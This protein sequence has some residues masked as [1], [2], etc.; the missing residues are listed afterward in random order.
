MDALTQRPRLLVKLQNRPDTQPKNLQ[1]DG[2]S[3]GFT[4]EPLFDPEARPA[5]L[6]AAAQPEWYAMTATDRGDEVNAWDLCHRLVRGDVAFGAAPAPLFAEPDLQQRWMTASDPEVAFAAATICPDNPDQ[7]NEKLPPHSNADHFWFLDNDHSQLDAA[8]SSVGDPGKGQRVRIAHLDTGYDPNH[9]TLPRYL[10]SDLARNYVDAD[11]PNDA[12]DGNESGLLTNLGHG[13]GTIGILAGASVGNI[14][15]GGA[16]NAEV[17][18]IRVANGVVLFYNSSIVKGLSRVLELTGTGDP[19]QVVH[20]ITMSMG[21]LASQAWADRINDLYDQGI[22]VVTAAGNNF[23]NLPTRNIVYPARFKRVVAA[24]GVMA[25]GSPYADLG[26][27]TMAG[28][29]GPASKMTTAIAAY[30]PNIIPWP[31]FGCKG[32]IDFD[33]QGTSAATPQIAATAALWIQKNRKALDGYSEP[34]M[35]VEAIRKALFDSANPPESDDLKARLGWGRVRS[36]KALD[37]AAASEGTLRQLKQKRD[38]ASFPFL[39]V[40]TG[41]GIQPEIGTN[42]AILE[43]E[44]LQLTQRSK[45]LEQLIPDPEV[46]EAALSPTERQRI[47]DALIAAPG[48]S[49]ALRKTL[50]THSIENRPAQVAVPAITAEANSQMIRWA[51]DP[52]IPPP[53]AIA[54]GFCL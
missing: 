12:T 19:Q 49:A 18:P 43:L 7:S 17:V 51:V 50:E 26:L 14:V 41:L 32:L 8:R 6:G 34:W 38:S 9:S 10:R 15:L 28:N 42:Q 35:R 52:K 39:R 22:F 44:A 45:E 11:R 3:V 36:G 53:F 46:A 21:G 30:S 54:E 47:L 16:P 40:I 13:T 4:F 20:V 5:R 48:A 23:G 27:T 2:A 37:Q 31:K 29:Y 1:L 25:D 33:G 24:C